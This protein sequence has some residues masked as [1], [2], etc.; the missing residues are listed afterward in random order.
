M[1]KLSVVLGNPKSMMILESL[2]NGN[3]ATAKQISDYCLKNGQEINSISRVYITL[4]QLDELGCI[5]IEKEPS[6]ILYSLNEEYKLPLKN[7]LKSC[8]N[9]D[10]EL[11]KNIG[12]CRKDGIYESVCK[13]N[14]SKYAWK[15]IL[16]IINGKHVRSEIGDE[17]MKKT[18]FSTYTLKRYGGV[19]AKTMPNMD[20][21]IIEHYVDKST[22]L[23]SVAPQTLYYDIDPKLKP[24]YKDV[25]NK[26]VVVSKL[27]KPDSERTMQ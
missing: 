21:E 17:L 15:L 14:K 5:N 23:W 26:L 6:G 9:L 4:Q 22:G 25:I 16:C 18:N 2:C 3:E 20:D 24:L 11:K 19:T 7:L 27:F 13:I 1:V 12:L 10:Q 8:K